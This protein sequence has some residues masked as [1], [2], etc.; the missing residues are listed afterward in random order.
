MTL[1]LELESDNP[2]TVYLESLSPGSYWAVR[3]SL[4]T[5]AEIL[6]GEDADPWTFP[7]HELRYQHTARVRRELVHRYAPATV[8]KMLSSLRGVLKNAWRL[9]MMDADTYQ[10]AS[11]VENL[12]AKVQP[13]GEAVGQDELAA[14]FQVC[15]EDPSPAGRR[16]AA[17]F[18]TLYG[19]GLRRAEL[20]GLDLADFDPEDCSLTVRA[21]KG[22]RDR[23]VY[24]PELVCQHLKAWIE[25]REDEPG[26][27]FGPVRMTG[28]VPIS[29][30]R[31]ESLWYVL[32]RRQRQAGL[33]GITPHGFRR[34]YI[35]S[36]LE[37]GVDLLTVQELVGH[38]NAV[39]T[40]RYDLRRES[41]RRV[42][43]RSL[44]LP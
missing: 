27:L 12:R 3:H 23:T 20:C 36:M 32:K 18:A 22:R 9:G 25:V 7:W 35:T 43:A 2:A 34:Q 21:G 44:A 15:S 30:L 13:K 5:I 6:A 17:M 28:E 31:G 4:E 42:A 8:N 40:A 24:L 39:T 19:G 33:K 41:A 16:D 37:A 1:P 14:L 11:A 26:P 38:A 29:R 10:R